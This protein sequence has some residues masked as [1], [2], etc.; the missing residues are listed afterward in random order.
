M[1]RHGKDVTAFCGYSVS[2]QLKSFV[3]VCKRILLFGLIL[4]FYRS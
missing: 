1:F 3:I 4:Y 2:T